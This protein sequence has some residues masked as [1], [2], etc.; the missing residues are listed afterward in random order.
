MLELPSRVDLDEV[1]RSVGK[2]SYSRGSAYARGK[3]VLSVDWNEEELALTGRVRGSGLYTTRVRFAEVGTEL[4]FVYGECTCPIGYDCK[5]V[6]AVAVAATARQ[7]PPPAP[8]ERGPTGATGS[9]GAGEPPVAAASTG[10]VTHTGPS[11]RDRLVPLVSRPTG[12]TAGAPLALE[13]VVTGG[14]DAHRRRLQAKLMRPGARGGWVNGS[15]TWNRLDPW[16]QRASALREDHLGIVRE[17]AS[18]AQAHRGSRYLYGYGSQDKLLDLTDVD[19]GPFWGLLEEARVRGVELLDAAGGPPVREIGSAELRLD[20]TVAVDGAAEAVPIMSEEPPRPSVL[21][22][23]PVLFLGEGG[24]G[25]LLREFG[26]PDGGARSDHGALRLL[27]LTRPA[28]ASLQTMVLA[29]ERV[30]I[31]AADLAAFTAEVAP[32]LGRVAPIVSHDGSFCA[33]EVSGPELVLRVEHGPEHRTWLDWA[34]RYRVGETLIDA[35]LGDLAAV[36][37]DDPAAAIRDRGAERALLEAIARDP[38]AGTVWG[39]SDGTGTPTGAPIILEGLATARFVAQALPALRE[40]VTVEETGTPADYRDVADSLVVEL[41]TEPAAGQTDWFDLGVTIRVAGVELAFAPVFAA[42]ARGETDLLL[43]DGAH[44]SL[45]VPELRALAQLIAEA[46]TL[47]DGSAPG[48]LRISRYQATLWEELVALGVVGAQAEAWQAQ[49]EALRGLEEVISPPLPGGFTATLR[50][51][52]REGFDWLATLWQL[53]LGG[54]LADDMGLGKT[55]QALALIAHAVRGGAEDPFLVVAPTSVLPNWMTEAQRFVPD[56]NVRAIADTHRKLGADILDTTAGAHIVVTTYTLLRL[57]ADRYGARR[58]AGLLLDEAQH[59]KNHNAKTHQAA[60]RIDAPF[61]LAITGTPMENNLTEL[62]ALLSITAPGLF[63]DPERFS[64]FWARPI[65]RHGDGERLAT[66]RRRIRPLLKRRTKELVAAELPAKQEQLLTVA[67]HPRHRTLYDRHLQRERTRI[68][69][70]LEDF[71]ANRL[72]VLTAITK[73]RQLSLHAGLIDDAHA[74][75]P[76]AKLDE[77]VTQLHEVIDGGHRALV[78]S[79]FT[80]FLARVRARLDAE[81]IGYCYLDGRTRNRER[82]L[83]RFKTGADPVFLISLKAGG[84]G[85]NLTEADYVFVL[86]PWWNPA[87]EAQAIDRSHR[88]GQTRPVVVYRLVSEGTVEEKVV[89]LARRKAQLF[90]G[91]MDDGDLFAGQITAADISGLLG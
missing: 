13:L 52:Q 78:F 85:L 16:D 26:E 55:V 6:A 34:V 83:T 90:S 33:P 59:V 67:L 51:Y 38:E 48:S 12:S 5:H 25:L 7:P 2:T 66:L 10:G 64:E 57:D 88:I 18:L 49:L 60:R 54:I 63:P 8:T 73:L 89:A 21:T 45:L 81:G 68:L 20:V 74:N 14:P 47:G 22:R 91:V 29:G 23:T 4:Q 72:S 53:G 80:G 3:R 15:L 27:R 61:K 9:A 84:A 24:H 65:E 87:V 40:S 1:A 79:Q 70:L 19:G 17:L 71:N 39:S 58:W 82:V 86:D 77:L 32:A 69:G 28:P 36:G 35:D 30:Q 75:V 37:G 76:S 44:F 31:P 42:L 50:P 11:W 62:W 46:R 41:S 56:L 43:D